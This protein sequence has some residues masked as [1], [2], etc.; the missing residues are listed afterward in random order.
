VDFTGADLTDA[1][2][3]T[4]NLK[5]ARF[6]GAQMVKVTFWANDVTGADFTD[7]DLTGAHVSEVDFATA[8]LCR[9]KLPGG[10]VNSGC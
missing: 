6:V 4:T 8:R 10:V 3:P 5:N 1:R 9:T 7:A 2:L